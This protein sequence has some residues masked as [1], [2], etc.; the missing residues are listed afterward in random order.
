[1]TT[2]KKTILV[3]DDEPHMRRLLEVGLAKIGCHIELVKSG[4][5]AVARLEAGPVDLLITDV[6]MSGMSGFE[7]VQEIRKNPRYAELPV[8]VMTGRGQS[9]FRQEAARLGVSSFLT[10]PFSP[11]DLAERV[12]ELLA[13]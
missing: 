12:K 4:H 7:A 5:E 9:R 13:L 10:K 11:I 6:E 1:M 2:Q 8:I 3:A